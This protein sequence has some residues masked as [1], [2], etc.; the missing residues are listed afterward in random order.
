MSIG[1]KMF[2][3]QNRFLSV[4]AQQS[5]ISRADKIFFTPQKHQT[6]EWE[7]EAEKAGHRVSLKN[8]TS[9]LI[10]GSGIPILMMHGW[11]GRATQMAG[12]IEPLTRLGYQLI[13]LDAPA[14]G[15]SEGKRS[16][17]MKFIETMF[18]AEQVFGPFYAVVGHSMG[19]GC[20]LYA[21]A[22][23]MK[24]EKLVSI[25][26]PSSFKRVSRRFA[27]FIGLNPPTID[28]FVEHVETT[29]GVPFEQIDLTSRAPELTLPALIVHDRDDRQIPFKDGE[30]IANAL[31]NGHL[32]ETVGMGHKAIMRSSLMIDTVTNFIHLDNDHFLDEAI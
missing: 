13:A 11:E 4:F 2:K 31:A 14:H 20:A 26:G 23:G 25:A 10:W 30:Y 16:N 1:F 29:V 6:K 7:N 28:R 24:M 22:E 18:L 21:A 9:A 27:N 12:F 19:G 5:A 32:Y 15:L 17:P 8:G 3:A